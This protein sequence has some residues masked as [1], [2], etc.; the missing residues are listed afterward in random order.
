MDLETAIQLLI[1]LGV[2][3][4]TTKLVEALL[5]RFKNRD[6]EERDAFKRLDREAQHRRVLQERFHQ[7]RHECARD[8]RAADGTPIDYYQMPLGPD[9]PIE[10]A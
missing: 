8:H 3:G 5:D 9:D 7:H 6:K 4:I 10:G 2:G 1:A